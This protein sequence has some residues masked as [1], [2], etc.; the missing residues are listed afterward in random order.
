MKALPTRCFPFL[1]YFT[2]KQAVLFFLLMFT[3]IIWALD[4][5]I[6]PYLLKLIVNHL[7]AYQ[8]ERAAVYPSLMPI[9]MLILGFW[10]VAEIATRSQGILQI[11]I[12]PYF[13]ANIRHAVFD[14]VK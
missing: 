10:F 1:V 3:S 5:T 14:Y 11:Y 7:M 8:G 13:R 4:E 6:F 12:F 2:K 9:L